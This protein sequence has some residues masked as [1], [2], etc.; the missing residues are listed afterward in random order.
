MDNTVDL[1]FE[2]RSVDLVFNGEACSV[3]KDVI[4]P[5][6]ADSLEE[7]SMSAYKEN[8]IGT[9][10][11]LSTSITFRTHEDASPDGDD[12][13]VVRF[14][15]DVQIQYAIAEDDGTPPIEL[16]LQPLS[17]D[18]GRIQFLST[19][20]IKAEGNPYFSTL[21]SV[22][23]SIVTQE[24][25]RTRS[26]TLTPTISASPTA[27]P[28]ISANPT[29][30]PSAYPT[31]SHMPSSAPIIA[32]SSQPSFSPS[33]FPSSTPTTELNFIDVDFY[34]YISYPSSKEDQVTD[35]LLS[36]MT[37]AFQNRF[38]K[39][40]TNLL[41]DFHNDP[42]V[43]FDFDE[44]RVPTVQK[45]TGATDEDCLRGNAIAI[46][47]N[48]CE[49]YV[50]IMKFQH[51]RKRIK[52]GPLL[53]HYVRMN[54]DDIAKE[55][56]ISYDGEKSVMK[57]LLL[58]MSNA[59]GPPTDASDFCDGLKEHLKIGVPAFNITEVL[60]NI[61]DFTV[62][63]GNRGLRNLQ[64]SDLGELTVEYTVIAEYR[65]IDGNDPNMFGT[66]VEDSINADSGKKVMSSLEERG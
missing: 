51:L 49:R 33:S 64:G 45:V 55:L 27:A 18:S 44:T 23:P 5:L 25:M 39:S 20:N 12:C 11:M 19:V 4:Y 57:D 14:Y 54:S 28:T 41:S 52:S 66:L 61:F 36:N 29:A 48:V 59:D 62:Y 1:F 17:T 31:I 24:G 42:R 56:K 21:S 3:D 43:A 63:A 10:N 53:T 6:L 58:I 30:Q 22:G 13:S 60:C 65:A 16:I 38:S 50:V 8:P 35:N 32:P 7:V 9:T 2:T 26:P 34:F 40:S 47:F 15:Y 37:Q 46:E